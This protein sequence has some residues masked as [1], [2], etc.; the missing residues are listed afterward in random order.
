M[1]ENCGLLDDTAR[2]WNAGRVFGQQLTGSFVS[3]VKS[4]GARKRIFTEGEMSLK[5]LYKLLMTAS[6]GM[7][8]LMVIACAEGEDEDV[9]TKEDDTNTTPADTGTS[10]DASVDT[11]TADSATVSTDDSEEDTGTGEDTSDT[12]LKA[13]TFDNGL[14]G[15]D[16]VWTEPE[17]DTAFTVDAGAITIEQSADD[18]DPDAG[19]IKIVANVT[20]PDYKVQTAVSVDGVDLTGR[21]IR[22]MIK[23]AEGLTDD[24]ENPGGAMVFAKTCDDWL[25]VDGGWTNITVEEGW[26]EI[27]LEADFPAYVDEGTVDDEGN[28]PEYDQSNICEIGVHFATGSNEPGDGYSFLP[29]TVYIDSITY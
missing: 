15:W 25:W 18:G 27:I 29:A 3:A 13:Y 8:L 20:G 24:P 28:Y 14:E 4:A 16:V 1:L 12:P 19:A 5:T 22:V 9:D 17:S 21:I 26:K 10:V 6:A 11:E 7:L 23:L 2:N